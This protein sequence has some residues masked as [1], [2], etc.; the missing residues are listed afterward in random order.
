MAADGQ[1][2]YSQCQALTD[3]IRIRKRRPG[4]SRGVVGGGRLTPEPLRDSWPREGFH[5]QPLI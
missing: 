3:L 1:L 5:S 2:V 4:S